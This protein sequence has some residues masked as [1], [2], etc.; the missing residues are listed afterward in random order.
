MPSPTFP[1][2]LRTVALPLLLSLMELEARDVEDALAEDDVVTAALRFAG[3]NVV[4]V[5]EDLL[6]V[7]EVENVVVEEE[8]EVVDVSFGTMTK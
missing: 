6:L 5:E 7:A 3:D 2:S 1:A 8:E 4:E